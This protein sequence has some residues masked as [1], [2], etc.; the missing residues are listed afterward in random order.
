MKWEISLECQRI[1]YNYLI[2]F[3]QSELPDM[4]WGDVQKKLMEVQQIHQI[5]IHKKELSELGIAIFHSSIHFIVMVF[6]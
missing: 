2:V 1:T 3:F 4:Q 5:S 6:F